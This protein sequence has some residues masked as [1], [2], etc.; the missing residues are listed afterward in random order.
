MAASVIIT[1]EDHDWEADYT[2]D[3]EPTCETEGEKSIHCKTCDAVKNEQ[4]LPMTEHELEKMRF[5]I[6]GPRITASAQQPVPA[7]SA[8]RK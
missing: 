2:I 5:P 3:Q 1:L 4:T 7:L 6:C 8:K